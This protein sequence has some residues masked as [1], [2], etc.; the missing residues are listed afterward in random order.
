MEAFPY[1]K[2]L[3]IIF[4]V[5]WFAG[6]FYIVRLF[7]YQTES[8]DK[9][10]PEKSILVNQFKLMSKRLWYGITWPSA[11][12][13][14]IFGPSLLHIY[15]PLT[16]YPFMIAKLV[17]VIFLYFYHFKC[18]QIFKALQVDNYN[19]SSTKLRVWN[20]VATVFLFAIVFL[21]ILQDMVSM[22]YGVLGLLLFSAIL[23]IAIK[24]YKNKRKA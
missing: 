11:I 7:I 2:A 9:S 5:T 18:H 6:L 21:I 10:E 13:T 1:L 8:A 23:M 19:W 20:E 24:V 17:F 3:H 16:K 12:A 15:M 4:I 14:L 22:V